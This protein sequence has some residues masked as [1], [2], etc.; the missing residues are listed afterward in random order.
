MGE[1]KSFTDEEGKSTRVILVEISREIPLYP[2]K[3][4]HRF[5][6]RTEMSNGS[7]PR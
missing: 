7:R 3:I 5:L 2:K 6:R 4:G 1:T